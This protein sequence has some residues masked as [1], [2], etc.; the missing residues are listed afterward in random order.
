[1][2]TCTRT[3]ANIHPLYKITTARLF[4]I[5][6]VLA[7]SGVKADEPAYRESLSRLEQNQDPGRHATRSVPLADAQLTGLININSATVAELALALPGIGPRK[8]QN[9]VDWRNDNGAFQFLDQLLEVSGIGPKTLEQIAPYITFGDGNAAASG[10]SSSKRDPEHRWVL[11]GIVD[12]ANKDAA[13][14]LRELN[15]S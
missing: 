8:A 7:C 13:Q 3:C 4:A 9:I 6:L 10:T 2:Q 15:G 11:L 14:V 1:M 5:I 12:R